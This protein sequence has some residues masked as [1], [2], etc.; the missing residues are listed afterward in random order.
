MNIKQNLINA[1]SYFAVV[2]LLAV[3]ATNTIKVQADTTVNQTTPKT[4]NTSPST[5]PTAST[6]SEATK[7]ENKTVTPSPIPTPAPMP[8]FREAGSSSD[9]LFRTPNDQMTP[10]SKMEYKASLGL[11]GLEWKIANKTD[12][13]FTPYKIQKDSSNFLT[14][15]A[16][17]QTPRNTLGIVVDNM[18]LLEP[19]EVNANL[20]RIKYPIG[21]TEGKY[22]YISKQNITQDYTVTKEN[23]EQKTVEGYNKQ[24]IEVNKQYPYL[25]TLA[26]DDQGNYQLPK[27]FAVELNSNSPE[28]VKE[29]DAIIAKSN[30]DNQDLKLP[31]PTPKLI[32][33]AV[34]DK[35][36]NRG[37]NFNIWPWIIASILFVIANYVIFNIFKKR[38]NR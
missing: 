7:T 17:N 16:T 14:I 8:E 26:V 32:S 6:T 35:S 11:D 2:L 12:Q 24:P 29:A 9:L 30:I 25:L 22:A 34:D 19:V 38:S 5:N 10:T 15:L 31:A 37:F 28:A 27:N 20:V 21:N 4:E 18:S 13:A 23:L 3:C 33:S 36:K 1:K